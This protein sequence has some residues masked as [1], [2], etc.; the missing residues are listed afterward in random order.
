MAEN[1][2]QAELERWSW[3]AIGTSSRRARGT[4]RSRSEA[5]SEAVASVGRVML[6]ELRDPSG[7]TIRVG[8]LVDGNELPAT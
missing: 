7:N 2:R 4:A 3:A 8:K 6:A 1:A 5:L